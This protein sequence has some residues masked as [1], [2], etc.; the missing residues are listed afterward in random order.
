MLV[1]DSLVSSIKEA[2]KYNSNIQIAPAAVLWT[3][4]ERQWEPVIKKLQGLLPELIVLSDY[5]PDKMTGPV[6]WIKCVL[7]GTLP[8]I[9]LPE[10]AVPIIYLP[11][12]SRS[13]LRA[14]ESCPVWLQGLAELQYRGAFWSQS[15]GK[16]WTVN[17]FLTSNSGG[18]GLE[19]A[20]DE[21][22]QGALLRVLETLLFDKKVQ[23]LKG[24]HLES[25]DFNQLV[26]SAPDKDLLTWMNDPQVIRE[27]WKGARWD[28]FVELTT[29]EFALN[30]EKEGDLG[31]AEALCGSE[32]AWSKV[33]QRFVENSRF[34]II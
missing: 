25:N 10:A 31:A 11:G 15:N 30:P 33:W 18:L 6:I 8:E 20:R 4:K 5:A 2:K 26:L 12:V 16:D 9:S 19:V 29:K 1:I 32:G 17:A 23:E 14:I 28:A 13:D 24:S 3:D 22:T 21:K 7:A 34:S 27:Q